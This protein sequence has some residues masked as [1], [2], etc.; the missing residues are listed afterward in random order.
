[1]EV[2]PLRFFPDFKQRHMGVISLL[3]KLTW[4][5]RAGR[6]ANW[7]DLGKRRGFPALGGWQDTQA[8]QSH[9]HPEIHFVSPL[10]F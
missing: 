10:T 8:A 6:S 9:F 7:M 4:E 5:A 3:Q 1:M 2:S